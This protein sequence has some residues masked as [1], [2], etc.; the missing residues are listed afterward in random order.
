MHVLGDGGGAHARAE[1]HGAARPEVAALLH[2]EAD[3]DEAIARESRQDPDGSVSRTVGEELGPLARLRA[4]L[5][6]V[7]VE[8]D[9]QP[10]GKDAGHQNE[11]VGDRHRA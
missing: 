3:G 8:A 9:A 11:V 5:A 1:E 10:F 4:L 7:V 2:R 6:G